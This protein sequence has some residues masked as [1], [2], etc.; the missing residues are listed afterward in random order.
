VTDNS[1]SEK[2]WQCVDNGCKHENG[3]FPN[4]VKC[5]G[6]GY[7]LT[8][9]CGWCF[10]CNEQWPGEKTESKDMAT[11]SLLP[12]KMVNL[13]NDRV[14]QAIADKIIA[15]LENCFGERKDWSSCL[16]FDNDE[17]FDRR[18]AATAIIVGVFSEDLLLENEAV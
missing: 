2:K 17:S 18:R 5:F 13:S 7:N 12:I 1:N 16:G 14:R 9:Y 11:T 6:C 10:T 8:S 3:G 15:R 4:Q